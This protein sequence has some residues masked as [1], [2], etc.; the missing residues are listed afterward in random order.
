ENRAVM[1]F[2]GH[3][4]IAV[5]DLIGRA[6]EQVRHPRSIGHAE[7]PR[8]DRH[9]LRVRGVI[10]HHR[11]PVIGVPSSERVDVVGRVHQQSPDRARPQLRILVADGDQLLRQRHGRIAGISLRPVEGAAVVRVV[12]ALLAVLV[13]VVNRGCPDIG[14]LEDEPEVSI[15]YIAATPGREALRIVRAELIG[16]GLL[17]VDRNVRAGADQPAVERALVDR[18]AVAVIV[19]AAHPLRHRLGEAVVV[20]DVV[21]L[22][23]V[24]EPGRGVTPVLAEDVGAGVDGMHRRAQ[25]L[26]DL[27]VGG[28]AAAVAARIER[29]RK[30]Q[31]P[32]IDG[33]G[34]GEVGL[35]DRRRAPVDLVAYR[36]AARAVIQFGHA[37]E[38]EEIGVRAGPGLEGVVPVVRARLRLVR[39]LVG[40]GDVVVELLL[41]PAVAVA[42]VIEHAIE[43]DVALRAVGALVYVGYQRLQSRAGAEGW[44]DLVVVLSVIL[45]DGGRI[46]NGIEVDDVRAQGLLDVAQLLVDARQVAA[47]EYFAVAVGGVVDGHHYRAPRV[48]LGCAAPVG[49]FA[50]GDVVGRVSIVKTI[51]EDLVHHS[52]LHPVRRLEARSDE[53]VARG[54]LA[55]GNAGGIEPG[56][57]R[58]IVDLETVVLLGAAGRNGALPVVEC[59]RGIVGYPDHRYPMVRAVRRI[60]VLDVRAGDVSLTGAQLHGYRGRRSGLR[61]AVEHRS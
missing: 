6:R 57:G 46:E 14:E 4:E 31:A 24:I 8:R 36:R 1:S 47:E 34:R 35:H 50:I 32:A 2:Y 28:I 52:V 42:A 25:L 54:R 18:G 27:M 5:G 9:R 29:L 56:S 38:A 37:A 44:I 43:D 17:H 39:A 23:A 12:A 15:P 60:V 22:R 7:L 30:I 58:A 53:E 33:V 59:A 11:D 19:H 49:I 10:E 13:P 40:A 20:H 16:P 55:R 21:P 51:G 45:V 41:K 3:G 26:R 48:L 61:I